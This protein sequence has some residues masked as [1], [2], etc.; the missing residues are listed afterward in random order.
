MMASKT[1]KLKHRTSNFKVKDED[2]ERQALHPTTKSLF[3]DNLQPYAGTREWPR[4][5]S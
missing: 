1:G 4:A 3:C 2:E 5:G